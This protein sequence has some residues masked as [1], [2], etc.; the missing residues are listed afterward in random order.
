MNRPALALAC[1]CLA[2]GCLLGGGG[3]ETGLHGGGGGTETENVVGRAV[4]ENGDPV[5]YARI[6]L[7]PAD[8]LADLASSEHLAPGVRDTVTDGQGRYGFTSLPSGSYRVEIGG[9]ESGGAINDFMLPESGKGKVLVPDTL[10]PRGS[11]AGSI[12]PDSESQSPCFV[13]VYGMQRIVQADPHGNFILYNMPKGTY[14]V[15]VSSQQPFRRE[16][17][18]KDITVAAGQRTTLDPVVL[19]KEAKLSFRIDSGAVRIDGLD[20]TNP[21]IFDNERWDN[22]PDNEYVWSKASAGSLDLRGAIVTRDFHNGNAMD[23]QLRRARQELWEARA[24]GFANLP[25]MIV[26]ATARLAWPD[27]GS[28]ENI[29]SSPSAGSELIVAEARKATPEKPLLVVVGGP[30]TTVANAWLTDPSIAPRMIVAGTYT[31]S[32]QPEDTVANYLVARKCRF[33]QWGRNYVWGGTPDTSQIRNIPA[34]IMGERLRVYLAENSKALPFGDLAP[35]A[36]LFN[37]G[38]WKSADIVK[39]NRSLE[40]QPASDITF[41]FVDIPEAGNDWAA[42]QSE[43]Y[44]GITQ[45]RAYHP[46]AL[47]GRVEAEAYAN[48]SKVTVQIADSTTG[49]ESGAYADGGY[50]DYRIT[51]AGGSFQAKIRYRSAGGAKLDGVLDHASA[52]AVSLTLPPASDWAEADLPALALDA[53]EHVL[54]FTISGGSAS[55]DWVD[56]TKP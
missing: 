34:T 38:A 22:G 5:A 44:A 48:M 9:T 12:A 8:Y 37:P 21:V 15:R 20:S 51:S 3:T 4:N 54:N 50:G 36:Y 31:Y 6:Q 42:F 26:G 24:A 30:L 1:L 56:F 35:V 46:F 45:A 7:R 10:R 16:A 19:A 13:Q 47:P 29:V 39:V 17:L 52:S 55:L 40:V 27:S 2:T 14:N 41:D 25:D 23:V 28:L 18:W 53:G 32:M 33:V 43:F 49:N 11:I